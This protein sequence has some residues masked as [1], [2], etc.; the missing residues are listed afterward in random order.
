MYADSVPEHLFIE[1]VIWYNIHDWFIEIKTEQV[2]IQ[3]FSQRLNAVLSVGQPCFMLR[4][5]LTEEVYFNR[6]IHQS[7]Y[8]EIPTFEFNKRFAATK[9]AIYITKLDVVR[10]YCSVFC[11]STIP[12]GISIV[13]CVLKYSVVRLFK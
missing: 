6:L 7:C 1:V 5:G 2:E 8:W 3:S 12:K 9:V 4:L 11:S 13:I 10:K